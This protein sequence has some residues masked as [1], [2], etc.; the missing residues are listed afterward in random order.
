LHGS[1][2]SFVKKYADLQEVS[3]AAYAAYTSEVRTG[4]FPSNAHARNMKAEELQKLQGIVPRHLREPTGL[5]EP[6]TARQQLMPPKASD[7]ASSAP[8]AAQVSQA[9]MKLRAGPSCHAIPPPG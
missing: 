2:P 4:D 6:A 9:V 1:V 3:A 8:T 5:A 7:R